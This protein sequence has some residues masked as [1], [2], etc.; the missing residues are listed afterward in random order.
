MKRVLLVTDKANGAEPTQ[1]PQQFIEVSDQD[2]FT[3]FSL[4]SYHG[5]R[6]GQRLD[7]RRLSVCPISRNMEKLMRI[8]SQKLIWDIAD[9]K[10]F[11][12]IATKESKCINIMCSP[13]SSA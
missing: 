1:E 8:V 7:L 3:C 13:I 6:Y 12:V 5:Y 2:L 9:Q 4:F 10:Y 11:L